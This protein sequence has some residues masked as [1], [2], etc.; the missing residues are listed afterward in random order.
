MEYWLTVLIFKTRHSNT[1]V[2]QYSILIYSELLNTKTFFRI[3]GRG[4]P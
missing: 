2:P 3:Y 1:P 4:T